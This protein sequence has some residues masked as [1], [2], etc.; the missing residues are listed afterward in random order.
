MVVSEIASDTRIASDSVIANSR[1][2][3]PTMPPISRIGRNTAISEKLIDITV[4]PTSR[5]PTS[6]A[7]MR[8][9]PSSRWREMFS[10][11]TMASSTTKPVDTV[12]AIS[13]RLSRLNPIRYI[14]PNVPMMETGTAIAG[15]MVA[16]ALRRNRNTTRV[17]R[18]TAITNVISVSLRLDRIVVL[19]SLAMVRFMSA[20]IAAMSCGIAAFT[21]S[22]V[23]MMLAPGWRNRITSTAG[24]PSE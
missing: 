6:A 13:D 3:R 11:T 5:A 24:W 1:N 20:G 7:C 14:A 10:S 9:M 18:T 8:G 2:S 22:T 19:R 21:A 17:T 15:I 12:S 4:K 23:S 16:R